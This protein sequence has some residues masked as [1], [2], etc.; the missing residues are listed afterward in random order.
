VTLH[1]QLYVNTAD[2]CEKEKNFVENETVDSYTYIRSSVRR[3]YS[4]RGGRGGDVIYRGIVFYPGGSAVWRQCLLCAGCAVGR[5]GCCVGG[6]GYP[7]G[8][9]ISSFII[10]QPYI[11]NGG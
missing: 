10:M 6:G 9:S 2:V 5:A 11:I 7:V 4:L 1:M 3:A 8:V